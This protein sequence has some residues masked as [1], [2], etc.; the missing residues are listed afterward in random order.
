MKAQID[1]LRN[2]LPEWQVT[3]ILGQIKL[4]ADNK[5]L[6]LQDKQRSVADL[7]VKYANAIKNLEEILNKN[8][9]LPEIQ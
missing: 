6:S 5:Q 9:K 8:V 3:D 7:V 1:E 2:N 4:I